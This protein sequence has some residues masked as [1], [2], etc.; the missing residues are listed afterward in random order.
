MKLRTVVIIIVHMSKDKVSNVKH[1]YDDVFIN[2]F[3]SQYQLKLVESTYYSLSRFIKTSK[4]DVPLKTAKNWLER[5]GIDWHGNIKSD[6]KGCHVVAYFND[7]RTSG[8]LVTM[9]S[10]H[11]NSGMRPS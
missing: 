6:A 7:C 3:V 10:F 8:S 4:S 5:R 1:H 9:R 2:S 11:T